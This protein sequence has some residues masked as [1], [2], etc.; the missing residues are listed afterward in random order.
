MV[1]VI[2]LKLKGMLDGSMYRSFHYT[3]DPGTIATDSGVDARSLSCAA[4]NSEGCYTNDQIQLRVFWNGLAD[5]I[6]ADQQR[7]TRVTFMIK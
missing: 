1:K 5:R 6:T 7:P 3:V 4:F 2:Q